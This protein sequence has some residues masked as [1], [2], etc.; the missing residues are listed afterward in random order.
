M[1]ARL[2]ILACSATKRTDAGYMPA[3]ERYNGPLWQTFKAARAEAAPIACA[4]LSALY[5]FGGED[6]PIQ[7]YNE[8]MTPERA[9]V[10]CRRIGYALATA[11]ELEASGQLRHA[12]RLRD[13]R[14]DAL[15]C[16][17]V[18]RCRDRRRRALLGGYARIRRAVPRRWPSDTGRAGYGN[19]RAYRLHA[20][21]VARVDAPG[22][23]GTG[24]SCVTLVLRA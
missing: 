23:R 8:R 21:T 16:A 4:F 20:P 14:I 6:R 13:C 12:C 2:V 1:S 5:G 22:M 11:A 9:R 7:D 10:H 18:R 15:P 17:T 24:E 19:Q 3:I